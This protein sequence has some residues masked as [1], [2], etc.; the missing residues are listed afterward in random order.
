MRDAADDRLADRAT[1]V[2]TPYCPL[3]AG[4]DEVAT[5]PLR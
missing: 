3:L 1:V 4:E 2:L 5:V